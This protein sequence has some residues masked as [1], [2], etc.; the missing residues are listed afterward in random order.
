MNKDCRSTSTYTM[1]QVIRIH[2]Q[3]MKMRHTHTDTYRQTDKCAHTYAMHV[4]V[5][6]YSSFIEATISTYA[7]CALPCVC[8]S[9]SC[10]LCVWVC[11]LSNTVC[12]IAHTHTHTHTI[13]IALASTK[14]HLYSLCIFAGKSPSIDAHFSSTI[15]AHT[16]RFLR[17]KVINHVQIVRIICALF[18]CFSFSFCSFFVC[19]G[20]CFILISIAVFA[21]Q[22][23]LK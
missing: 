16:H 22:T 1:A 23:K 4:F 21:V 18:L 6:L 2:W 10:V 3:R 14:W 12:C 19:G 20:C 9:G 7:Q 17:N 5:F 15:T 13:I 11:F 8:V